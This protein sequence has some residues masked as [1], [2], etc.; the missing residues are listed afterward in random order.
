MAVFNK[1][2]MPWVSHKHSNTIPNTRHCLYNG[3]AMVDCRD[4]ADGTV[5]YW[6]V[7]WVADTLT[8]REEEYKALHMTRPTSTNIT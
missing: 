5:T 1:Y 4:L 3:I 8:D 7:F 2:V 6:H